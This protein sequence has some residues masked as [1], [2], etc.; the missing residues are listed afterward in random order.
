MNWGLIGCGVIGGRRVNA[1][2]S[3]VK[4]TSCFD[5][6][7]ER[8]Q[9]I[10][11]ST[12]AKIYKTADELLNPKE[13]SAVVIAAINSAL[14]PLLQ[15]AIS[16]G[17]HALVEKPAARS[18]TELS[19][20]SLAG[21]KIKIGFNHRFHPAFEDL[22]SQIKSRQDDP[23][24]FIRAQYGNGARLGFESEWRAKPE[25]SGGGELLDQG[26]HVLDLA[27]VLLPDLKV[28]AGY[29]KTHY[30]NMPVDDNS[31]AILSN[32]NGPSASTFSFHVSSSEWKNEFRFEVYTRQR[33]YQWLGLGRSYGPEK[34]LI[35]KMKPEMGPPDFEE[36]TYPPEDHSWLSE[37]QNFLDSI[38]G[39]KKI[40]GGIEDALKCLKL[41][42]SIYQK[43]K[44]LQ[45]DQ[46]SHPQWW[47]D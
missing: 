43:S 24:L 10:S 5:P 17:I 3:G 26:V 28:M 40:N 33:K 18:F 45:I 15:M 34:L 46:K 29:C 7:Q 31:W 21:T 22:V 44:D 41:V 23:I 12:G 32:G 19:S 6:N 25:I 30:W 38:N 14:A 36:K 13:I 39:V 4:L 9:A 35:Y 16:R 8:A 20:V 2:P 47:H 37:N 11:N 27:S 42:E 1:L